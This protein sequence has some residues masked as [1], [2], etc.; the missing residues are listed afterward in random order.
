MGILNITPDSFYDGDKYNS[1]YLWLKQTEKMLKEGASI[2]D[3]GV[4]STRPGAKKISEKEELQRLLPVL[5]SI[6]KNFSDLIISVDTYRSGIAEIAVQNSAF[7]INDISGGTFDKKMFDTIAKLQV[8]YIIMH[9]KGAPQ[10]MQKNPTYDNVVK[11]IKNFFSQQIKKLNLKGIND[12]IID[13]GFGF[14]KTL[15]HNYEILNN[16]NSFNAFGLP[17]LAGISRKSMINKVLNTKP[18]EALN[19][20]TVLN[21]IC[22]LK[23][24]K[25]L[26]VH[27]V[28]EAMEV[29][30]IVSQIST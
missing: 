9:I 19:G 12:I 30:K 10:N 2:I 7:M 17:V 15:K 3:I 5:T 16:L 24:A 18:S 14:G 8:P 11:E 6:V 28:K 23:G 26:R 27:D 4:V 29:I 22:L 25:I 21:T 20:T 13:P 1:E